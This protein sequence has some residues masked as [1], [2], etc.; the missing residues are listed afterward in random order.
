MI[1]PTFKEEQ[2]LWNSGH[3]FVCGIDEV[4]RGSF[5]GPVVVGAVIF[6]VDC[7]LIK[8]VADSK[9]VKAESRELLA[10]SIKKQALCWAIAEVEVETINQIGIGKATQMAFTKVIQAL[11]LQP[12]FVLVD[13]FPILEFDRNKQKA[14]IGGDLHCFS[15]SASS[16]IAKVYRDELMVKLHQY[17][18]NYGWDQNKG[19]GTKIHRQAIKKYGLSKHHRTSFNLEKFL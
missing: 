2:K 18:P 15:I 14:L 17:N 5:A 9:L 10:V 3:K 19:Y 12:D 13:A 16:I 8:G 1:F 6:P 4:G 11:K 7:Q